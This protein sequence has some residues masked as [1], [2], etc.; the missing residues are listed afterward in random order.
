MLKAVD[1][2]DTAVKIPGINPDADTNDKTELSYVLATKVPWIPMYNPPAV[3]PN[4]GLASEAK[5]NAEP[6]VGITCAP[7]VNC[8]LVT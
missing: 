2:A 8:G 5:S 6:D 7:P 1:E 4:W 3:N